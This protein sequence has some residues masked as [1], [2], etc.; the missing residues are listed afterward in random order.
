MTRRKENRKKIGDHAHAVH[1]KS[2]DKLTQKNLSKCLDTSVQETSDVRMSERVVTQ[3]SD[4]SLR[5]LEGIPFTKESATQMRPLLIRTQRDKA[6]WLL[7]AVQIVTLMFLIIYVV[8]T[9]QIA[10]STQHATAAATTSAEIAAKVAKMQV[11]V[12]LIDQ[13]YSD[14]VVQG[15][16][17]SIFSDS[18]RFKND[19]GNPVISAVQG[20]SEKR[21]DLEVNITLNRM[22]ILG[23]LYHLQ[24]LTKEDLLGLRYEIISVGR[25]K[26]VR[27]YNDFLNHGYQSSSGIVHDHFAYLKELYLAFEYDPSQKNEFAKYLFSYPQGI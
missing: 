10:S 25:N 22:Q 3:K 26:A 12:S 15:T 2:S 16:L 4:E 7:I 24:I 13:L 9:W 23:Q 21:V 1:D 18:L 20:I 19:N 11:A 14:P 8:K 5:E 6:D 17:E 27:E